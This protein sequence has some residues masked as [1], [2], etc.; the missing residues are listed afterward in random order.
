[1]PHLQGIRPSS[2]TYA[3]DCHRPRNNTPPKPLFEERDLGADVAHDLASWQL[4]AFGAG[5]AEFK[6]W[7]YTCSILRRVCRAS[8]ARRTAVTVGRVP[9]AGWYGDP[10]MPNSRPSSPTKSSCDSCQD[11]RNTPASN[12]EGFLH[13]AC[14]IPALRVASPS[15]ASG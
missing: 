1:M 13:D 8:R 3:N 5:L 7:A 12:S 9:W 15:V 14:Y 4:K 6:V 2:E 10:L 11:L